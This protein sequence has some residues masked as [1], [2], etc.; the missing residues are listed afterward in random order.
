M[1]VTTSFMER[2]SV[3]PH[4]ASN[5]AESV[6]V[7]MVRAGHKTSPGSHTHSAQLS[8]AGVQISAGVK[9]PACACTPLAMVTIVT[10]RVE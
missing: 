1:E 10:I 5:T 7:P 6:S 3:I 2:S 4:V 9:C 8:W